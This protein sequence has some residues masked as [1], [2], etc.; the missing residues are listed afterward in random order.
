MQININEKLT[1]HLKRVEDL[2]IE[3]EADAEEGYS[4][5]A[6]AMTAVTTMLKELVKVQA[7]VINMERLMRLEA[8][9]IETMKEFLPPDQHEEFLKKLTELFEEVE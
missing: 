3:A 8:L 5:R 6:S 7:E 9:T 2:A 1:E 4:S